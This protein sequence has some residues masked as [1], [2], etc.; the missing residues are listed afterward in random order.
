MDNNLSLLQK[1]KK[2]SI[3][4]TVIFL[5][6]S[7]VWGIFLVLFP[8]ESPL[9]FLRIIGTTTTLGIFSLLITSSI[10]RLSSSQSQLNKVLAWISLATSLI[11]TIILVLMIWGAFDMRCPESSASNACIT[12]WQGMMLVVNKLIW[13]CIILAF[14]TAINNRYLAYRADNIAIA[15]F[16]NGTIVINT[17]LGSI[18]ILF[19]LFEIPLGE[20]FFKLVVIGSILLVLGLIVTPILV[21]AEKSRTKPSA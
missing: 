6:L 9:L 2:P 5:S 21:L 3:I 11:A 16:R 8:P 10:S 7:A 18:Y 15:I 12:S 1:L 19:I 17:L 20:F 14:A 4:A 13:S